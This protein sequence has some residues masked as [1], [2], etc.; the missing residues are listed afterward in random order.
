MFLQRRPATKCK[1]RRVFLGKKIDNSESRLTDAD[2]VASTGVLGF[3][4]DFRKSSAGRAQ[5]LRQLR[6]RDLN[7]TSHGQCL[8]ASSRH[9]ALLRREPTCNC[10]AAWLTHAGNEELTVTIT[11]LLSVLQPYI[12]CDTEASL[13]SLHKMTTHT[14]HISQHIYY[15]MNEMFGV[16]RRNSAY[17]HIHVQIRTRFPSSFVT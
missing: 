6:T 1:P 9:C 5:V 2:L 14:W 8:C 10:E 12:I 15:F 11:A 13:S 4:Y 17:S 16:L 7:K 3:A